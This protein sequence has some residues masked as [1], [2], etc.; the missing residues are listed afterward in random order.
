MS[1]IFAITIRVSR[2]RK[3]RNY[4]DFDY[5][6]EKKNGSNL[7]FSLPCD[8]ITKFCCIRRVDIVSRKSLFS[9]NVIAQHTHTHTLIRCSYVFF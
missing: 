5:G 9:T 6:F 7:F 2:I 4:I 1:I 8:K 3:S